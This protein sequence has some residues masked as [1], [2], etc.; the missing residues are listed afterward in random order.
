MTT[1]NPK[2]GHANAGKK[3]LVIPGY[4]LIRADGLFVSLPKLT[5]SADFIEFI[6][7]LFSGGTRFAN[8]NYD[9][10]LKVMYDEDWRMATQA[11]TPE[12]KLASGIVEFA[13]HRQALYRSVKVL[14]SGKYADY[15]FEPVHVEVSIDEP[16]YGEPGADGVAPI[17]EYRRT[18]KLQTATLDFDEFVAVMWNKGVK[19]GIHEDE[20]RASI[21]AGKAERK[22]VAHQLEPTEGSDAGIEE[23]SDDLHQDNTPKTLWNGKADLR[24]F[25]NRFP[26]ITKGAR[27]LKKIKKVLGKPGYKVTGEVIEPLIPKDLNFNVLTSRGTSV[28]YESGDEFIVAD[29]D[30][31]LTIDTAMNL[32]SITEKIETVGGISMKTTGDLQLDVEE[33]IEHGEVQE[34]RVVKGRHMT[35]KSSVFGSLISSS[36]NINVEGNLTG[37]LAEAQDGNVTL[38]RASR[39]VIHAYKGEITARHCENCTIIGK[40]ISIE[41]AVNCEIVGTEISCDVVEGGMLAGSVIKILSA[42]ESR[43]RENLITMLV[44]DVTEFEQKIAAL[45]EKIKVCLAGMASKTQEVEQLKAADADFAKFLGLSEKIRNGEIKLSSEQA[46]NWQK[47]MTK[48]ASA[49]NKVQTLLKQVAT[50]E[51]LRNEAEQEISKVAQSRVEAGAGISCEIDSISG[52]SVGQTMRAASGV[53]MFYNKSAQEIKAIIQKVDGLKAPIFTEDSGS[54]NW[55]YK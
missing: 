42:G 10:F 18:T 33:F 26:Q 45:Q 22:I 30:G 49:Y 43:S 40:K 21:A 34:G 25:K 29:I 15:V 1:H 44:P 48:H 28:L 31:F 2:T 37:G 13:Q 24:A 32:V 50:L 16:V 9:I 20:V 14:E 51:G 38:D 6:D 53:S 27:L 4:I 17:V 8:L 12:V 35:F 46:G 41:K 3:N 39:A 36:G 52:L 11:T 55:Q 54:I 7:H 47:L 19:Y 5:F 23:L